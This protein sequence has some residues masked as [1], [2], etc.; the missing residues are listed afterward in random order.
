MKYHFFNRVQTRPSSVRIECEGR[1]SRR[2]QNWGKAWTFFVLSNLSRIKSPLGR[3]RRR[4]PARGVNHPQKKKK[5][6]SWPLP[7]L[8]LPVGT[9]IGRSTFPNSSFRKQ[10]SFPL[11]GSWAHRTRDFSPTV[12]ENSWS[13]R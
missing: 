6:L 1:T 5:L 3:R 2:G 12:D 7:R 11:C 8:T 13:P 9:M 10:D 4:R